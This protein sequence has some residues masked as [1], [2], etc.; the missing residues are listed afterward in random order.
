MDIYHRNRKFLLLIILLIVITM[1]VF[2]GTNS[3]ITLSP[4]EESVFISELIP[5]KNCRCVYIHKL[6]AELA[7]QNQIAIKSIEQPAPSQCLQQQPC[8]IEANVN[9]GN[10]WQSQIFVGTSAYSAG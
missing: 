5:G 8:T 4:T 10:G 3:K 2:T 9:Q 7:Q 1:A 6:M